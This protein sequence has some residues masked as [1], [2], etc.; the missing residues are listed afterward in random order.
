MP[1]DKSIHDR[2]HFLKE[3]GFDRGTPRRLRVSCEPSKDHICDDRY[4]KVNIRLSPPVIFSAAIHVAEYLRLRNFQ[5]LDAQFPCIVRLN[6]IEFFPLR[7]NLLSYLERIFIT[8]HRLSKFLA[9][10]DS[11][12]VTKRDMLFSNF[13]GK[14]L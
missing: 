7:Q 10:A 4:K 5:V 8:P 14:A 2:E 6:A 12:V 13:P 3:T 1:W 11:G 9:R